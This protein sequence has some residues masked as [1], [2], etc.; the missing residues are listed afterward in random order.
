MSQ[1]HPYRPRLVPSKR[2][3]SLHAPLTAATLGAVLLSACATAPVDM[4]RSAPAGEVVLE[5]PGD[6]APTVASVAPTEALSSPQARAQYHILAGEMAATRQ[7]PGVAAAEFIEALKAVEDVELA[8]RATALAVVARDEKLAISAAKRW[9]ELAPNS[10][11]P[12]EVLV[13]LSLQSGDLSGTLEHIRELIRGNAGG[14]ADGFRHVTQL[15]LPISKD[16]ADGALSIAGQLVSEWPNEA[17][18]HHAYAALALAFD[19]LGLAENAARKAHELDPKDRDHDLLLIGIWTQ[20]GRIDEASTHVDKLLKGLKSTDAAEVRARY[21]RLLLENGRRDAARAQ[22][23][24][25]L[26]LDTRSSEAQYALAVMAYTDSDYDAAEKYLKPLLENG[27]RK[28]EAALLLGRIAEAQSRFP[29][30]L[31]YYSKVR[32]G[33]PALDAAVRSAAVFARMGDLNSARR[34][35]Q[36]LR[37]RFPQLAP[38]FYAAEGEILL[39]ADNHDGA[40]KLYEEALGDNANDGDLL[41]GRSLAY[42]R[43]GKIELAEKDLRTSIQNDPEDARALNALGYMLVVHTQRYDEAE[44]LIKRALALE[45][46]DAAIIDSLGWLQFK[47]GRNEEA[48]ILLQKAYAQYPDPEVAAHLGEVL[49]TLDDR[50]QALSIWQRALEQNPGHAALVETMKRLAP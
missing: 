2:S 4:G 18:A 48:L 29:Q 11:E 40:L 22:F 38:R 15:M 10:A 14:V 46:D 13:S 8:E 19:Q 26:K 35:L 50:E 45:P 17:A 47:Q 1:S 49:W 6:D 39:N 36:N 27:K 34:L 9:L 21:A 23:D 42:E 12:R 31:D 30:A 32:E 24:K 16:R 7:Q 43:L 5:T 41:Y 44:G 20:Q 33:S 28:S 25:V 3:P 37:D